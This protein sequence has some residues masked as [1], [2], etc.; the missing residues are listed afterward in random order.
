MA[1]DAVD[2]LVEKL[3]D[4]LGFKIVDVI[5]IAKLKPEKSTF[6]LNKDLLATPCPDLSKLFGGVKDE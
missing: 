6:G 4:A 5:D 1:S 2:P 3:V